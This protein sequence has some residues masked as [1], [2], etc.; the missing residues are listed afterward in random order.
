MFVHLALL[1]Q[2]FLGVSYGFEDLSE[3]AAR[4]GVLRVVGTVAQ[5]GE[6]LRAGVPHEVVGAAQLAKWDSM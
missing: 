4:P 6:A 5:M 3:L 1:R 2:A